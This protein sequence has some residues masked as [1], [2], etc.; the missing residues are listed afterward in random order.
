MQDGQIIEQIKAIKNIFETS[1]MEA[2]R[3]IGDFDI[4]VKTDLSISSQLT[5]EMQ[6]VFEKLYKE[7]LYVPSDQEKI[8]EAQYDGKNVDIFDAGTDFSMLAKRIGMKDGDS[9]EIWNRLS[10]SHTDG[11][12]DLRYNTC[13]SYMQDENLLYGIGESQVIL[14]FARRNRTLFN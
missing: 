5:E 6:E 13:L 10:Q 3:K 14:G 1:D 8:G 12:G 7:T 4:I 2:L 11:G 9:R